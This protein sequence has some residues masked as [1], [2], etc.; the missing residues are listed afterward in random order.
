[1]RNEDTQTF[2]PHCNRGVYF[3]GVFLREDALKVFFCRQNL[4]SE[5]QIRFF[6]IFFNANASQYKGC[7]LVYEKQRLMS[8]WKYQFSCDH[9]SQASWA[10]PVFRGIKL[11]EEWWFGFGLVYISIMYT[12]LNIHLKM[13]ITTVNCTSWRTLPA[14][15][16][17]SSLWSLT[18]W[19]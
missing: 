16:L 9:W 15:G 8:R 14:T 18:Y 2:N 3:E 19:Y 17:L 1:M 10:Q 6:P 11:F 13:V 12:Q 7:R 4:K 5:P